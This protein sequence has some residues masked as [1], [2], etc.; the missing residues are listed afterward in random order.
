MRDA[1]V[2]LG[3][4]RSGTSAVTGTLSLLGATPPR[5]LMHPSADYG[6]VRG[7]FESQAIAHWNDAL[8]AS[9]GSA[10]D[11]W[12]AFDRAWLQAPPR[13]FVE[14]ASRLLGQEFESARMF[15]LK[16]PRICRLTPFWLAVLR[17]TGVASRVVIP[18]RPPLEVARSLQERDGFSIEKGLLLW[19]RHVLDAERDTRGLRR[20][21]VAMDAFLDDWRKNVRRIAREIGIAWPRDSARAAREI[22]NFLS[23]DMKHHNVVSLEPSV[24]HV[25]LERAYGALSSLSRRPNSQAAQAVLDDVSDAFENACRLFGPETVMLES[26]VRRLAIG[27]DAAPSSRNEQA[28]VP[29]SAPDTERH[30]SPLPAP[31][32]DGLEQLRDLRARADEFQ[33]NLER[34]RAALNAS[35]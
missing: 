29:P 31:A 22:D 23:R 30:E 21:F 13:A 2:V 26:D 35:L 18:F 4:H 24:G 6:N 12:R 33:H 14:D 34:L 15:A 9:A 20:S 5:T 1:I 7:F 3:M 32:A 28:I 27:A 16:D 8:L 11:D 17:A 10:W 19:L 25:W